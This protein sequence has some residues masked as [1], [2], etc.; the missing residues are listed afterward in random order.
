MPRL[1]LGMR[2]IVLVLLLS[3]PVVPLTAIGIS[4]SHRTQAVISGGNHRHACA[5]TSA[6]IVTV[7]CARALQGG[8]HPGPERIGAGAHPNPHHPLHRY[9]HAMNV[10]PRVPRVADYWPPAP[11]NPYSLPVPPVL[12]RAAYLYDVSRGRMLYAWNAR[13]RLPNASTTK[14]MT[15]LLG[16]M[17]GNLD[18]WVTTSYTAANIGGSSMYLRQGERLRMRDLLYGLLMPSGNDASIAI[19]DHIGGSETGFVNMMNRQAAQLG[20]VDTHYKNPHGLD[21]DGHYT[22]ARDMALLAIA[23]MRSPLF[24]QIVA[25]RYHDIP[26]ASHNIDHFLVNINQPLWWY[27]G[28]IG[29]KPGTT[30]ASGR[31]AVEWVQRGG[32]ELVLVVLGDVNLVT[33]VRDLFNWGFGDF[34]HWFSPLQAPVVYAP[35]YFGWDSPG[36]WVPLPGGGRYYVLTGHTVRPPL[37]AG[38]LRDGGKLHIGPPTSEQSLDHGIWAQRF[39][40]SWLFYS[41][42]THR[43][44]P[45]ARAVE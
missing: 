44:A 14:I 18:D 22:S 31:C 24:R 6:T 28:T 19:A 1:P 23:A 34:S 2:A 36:L 3:L 10:L 43:T 8:R 21:E 15:A 38:Y 9:W 41:S 16:I 27:P 5:A 45:Y 7:S 29:V 30:G 37:L 13:S 17:Y 35:E 20:M 32:R 33:D 11:G 12:A 25:T 42:R 26:A 40:G 4:G 39:A